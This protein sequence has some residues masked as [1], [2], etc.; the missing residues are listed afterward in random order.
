[1]L[2]LPLTLVVRD[3][4]CVAVAHADAECVAVMVAVRHSVGEVEGEPDTLREPEPQGLAELEPERVRVT[5]P[6]PVWEGDKHMD[7]VGE[8]EALGDGE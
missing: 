2:P 1:M 3:V 5:L 6:E 8:R 4:V 7:G